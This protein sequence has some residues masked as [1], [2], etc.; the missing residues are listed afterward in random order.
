MCR[1][2]SILLEYKGF[3]AS[4]MF[5]TPHSIN[6]KIFNVEDLKIDALSV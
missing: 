5:Q 3:L 6:A 4:E 2:K 1:K